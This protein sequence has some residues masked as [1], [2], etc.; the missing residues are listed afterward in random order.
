MEAELLFYAIKRFTA[1]CWLGKSDRIKHLLRFL[2]GKQGKR[3]ALMRKLT[4]RVETHGI[5]LEGLREENS[6][7]PMQKC[8]WDLP[9]CLGFLD[10][11]TRQPGTLF[12][13]NIN[14]ASDEEALTAVNDLPD[15]ISSWAQY[16]CWMAAVNAAANSGVFENLVQH[17]GGGFQIEWLESRVDALHEMRAAWNGV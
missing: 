14:G 11:G 8:A 6:S 17:H 12:Q 13:F 15:P 3:L 7:N 16:F 2:D 4:I 9:H 5:T 10:I 1:I